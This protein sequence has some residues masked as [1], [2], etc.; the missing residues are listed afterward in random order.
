MGRLKDKESLDCTCGGYFVLIGGH[1]REDLTCSEWYI[2]FGCSSE[3]FVDFQLGWEDDEPLSRWYVDNLWIAGAGLFPLPLPKS[4]NVFCNF[5]YWCDCCRA[6]YPFDYDHAVLPCEHDVNEAVGVV[7]LGVMGGSVDAME[8]VFLGRRRGP[9]ERRLLGV[10]VVGC[11]GDDKVFGDYGDKFGLNA[12]LYDNQDGGER[13]RVGDFLHKCGDSR[14]VRAFLNRWHPDRD[15][16][17]GWRNAELLPRWI[18][19]VKE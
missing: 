6:M 10:C 7:S 11:D 4:M 16:V 12:W 5:G 13:Q 2:C 8:V 17:P 3:C 18:Y 1:E 9:K 15:E 19:G 14:L